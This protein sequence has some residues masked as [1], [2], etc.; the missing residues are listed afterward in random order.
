MN[1]ST[2][3]KEN[4]EFIFAEY[5]ADRITNRGH[6]R[7]L[8]QIKEIEEKGS[9]K[10]AWA[11]LTCHREDFRHHCEDHPPEVKIKVGDFT[12]TGVPRIL[13]A[14]F[15][16]EG[17]IARAWKDATIYVHHLL[18]RGVDECAIH[19]YFSGSKGWHVVNPM[20]A[21]GE[22]PPTKTSHLITKGVITQIV[23]DAGLL[24]SSIDWKIYKGN[25]PLRLANSRHDESGQFK[26]GFTVGEFLDPTLPVRICELARIPRPLD[27][28]NDED[29]RL[30]PYLCMVT[31]KALKN[32]HQLSYPP[33]T[34]LPPG[35]KDLLDLAVR[36]CQR[37]MLLGVARGQRILTGHVMVSMFR[38]KGFSL[39]YIEEILFKWNQLNQPPLSKN[40]L[41][42]L[43]RGEIYHYGC[44][45]PVRQEF[46]DPICPFY[47]QT[48]KLYFLPSKY[49]HFDE[50]ILRE[51]FETDPRQWG[52][53][54]CFVKCRFE[55][56]R[57]GRDPDFPK[58]VFHR[59]FPP[60]VRQRVIDD[61]THEYLIK[62][63]PS[64]RKSDLFYW[65]V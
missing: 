50:Q 20:S 44:K 7:T 25:Q 19:P 37:N 35:I 40:D 5:I 33:T 51:G 63:W 53:K 14:D 60:G 11:G 10:P 9:D 6:V 17:E 22:I 13:A 15:D 34:Q 1:N 42:W 49:A 58:G 39:Q 64:Q 59:R 3:V 38:E 16:A 55:T 26:V 27:F 12:G 47:R 18:D 32:I 8:D 41:L 29:I 4:N 65:I 54:E 43:L 56:F 52:E 57:E 21:L 62:L 36:P 45:H 23:T 30:Q 31:E 46:C 24:N 48:R 28:P 61:F 2:E